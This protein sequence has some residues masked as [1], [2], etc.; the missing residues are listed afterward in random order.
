[1]PARERSEYLRLRRQ[2]EPKVVR[3]IVV[4]ESPPVSGKYFYDP[5][6]KTTEAL[7]SA[8]MTQLRFTPCT[9]EEGL[10]EFKRQ[11]W[12]LVDATYQ[13]VNKLEGPKSGRDLVI[14]RDYPR[15]K[16]DLKALT[17]GRSIPLVLIKANVCRI[18]EPKLTSDGFEVLN[19]ER[20][21]YFPAAGRQLQFQRQFRAILKSTAIML[22]RK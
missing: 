13:A 6:G 2:Y 7:F 18:L 19:R 10:D 3:L 11:G 4:A 22:L 9:K 15:L 16:R 8:M 1:M 20:V 12:V 5:V 21:V 17:R 14:E